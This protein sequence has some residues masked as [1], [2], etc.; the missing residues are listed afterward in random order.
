MYAVIDDRG[1]QHLVREG[2]K[3]HID[4]RRDLE[5][6]SSI[7]FDR[8]LLVGGDG[9]GGATVGRPVVAGAK[10]V[11]SVVS[12]FKDKKLHI[13]Y[14]RRRKNFRRHTGHRQPLTEI[15]IQ[16]IVR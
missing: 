13:G 4:F 14:Y 16:Q 7:E 3:V 2:E 15:V 5:P 10:V 8:V 11:A 9:V 6:G 12:H 1:S